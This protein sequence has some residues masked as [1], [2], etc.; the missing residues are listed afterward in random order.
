MP[1][2]FKK[3]DISL[4]KVKSLLDYDPCTGVFTWK[5]TKRRMVKGAVAGFMTSTGYKR[6]CI[7][8]HELKAH[9]L[10]W[11]YVYGCWPDGEL[12]HINRNRIDNKISNLRNASRSVNSH[13][14]SCINKTGHLGIFYNKS[15]TKYTAGIGYN[16]V[17]YRFG[18]FEN[19]E[20]AIA[21]Y[22]EAE[23]KMYGSGIEL[24]EAK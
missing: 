6:I 7:L 20:D 9:R 22:K 5:V 17:F 8:G 16:N 13:N 19:I 4:E 18:T 3:P 1:V 2:T 14:R 21:A 24:H 12:D 15:K 11:F 23:S 10:A